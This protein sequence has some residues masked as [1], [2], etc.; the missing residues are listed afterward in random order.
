MIIDIIKNTPEQIWWFFILLIYLGYSATL[1]RVRAIPRL[2]LLPLV[3]FYMDIKTSN[4]IFGISISNLYHNLIGVLLGCILGIL[5]VKNQI[6]FVDK[7]KRLVKLP[8][9]Y[10]TIVLVLVNFF[11]HYIVHVLYFFQ[12]HYLYQFACFIQI[13]IGTLSGISIG[14]LISYLIKVLKATHQDL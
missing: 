14:R 4:H 5:L 7:K 11:T 3:L 6:I 9:E 12:N 8:G 13:L 1:T 2:F 10:L